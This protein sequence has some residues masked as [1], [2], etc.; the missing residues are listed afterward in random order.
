MHIL[1]GNFQ[2][3]SID[4]S[5]YDGLHLWL[6]QSENQPQPLTPGATKK[7]LPTISIHFQ[8]GRQWERTALKH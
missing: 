7:F 3:L 8:T 4:T 5:P 6:S 1:I 2:S